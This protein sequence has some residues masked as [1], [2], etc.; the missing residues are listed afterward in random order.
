[1][2]VVILG[3]LAAAGVGVV[4]WALMPSAPPQVSEEVALPQ[5]LMPS[6]ALG[7]ARRSFQLREAMAAPMQGLAAPLLRGRQGQLQSEL[8]RAHLQMSAAQ[9]VHIHVGT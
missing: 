4:V 3:L 9:F 7:K 2:P 6:Q 1:M 8:Q 5:G